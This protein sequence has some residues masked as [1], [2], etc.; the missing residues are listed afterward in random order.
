MHSKSQKSGNSILFLFIFSRYFSVMKLLFINI[1]LVLI[2]TSCNWFK[3]KPLKLTYSAKNPSAYGLADGS[4]NLHIEGGRK[5]YRVEWSN[6]QVTQ[7][8]TDLKA[9]KYLAMV[10]DARNKTVL[11]NIELTCYAL[12]V[13]DLQGNTYKTMTFGNKTWMVEN[14]RTFTKPDGSPVHY[15]YPSNDSSQ[16]QQYGLLYDWETAMNGSSAENTQGICPSGWHIPSD[17]EWTELTRAF[18]RFQA[19]KILMDT[20]E[21]FNAVA[22]GFYSNDYHGFGQ[23]ANFWTSTVCADNAWKRFIHKNQGEV[24]RYHG[25]KSHAYSVRCVKDSTLRKPEV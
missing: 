25:L 7:N 18:P 15:Y 22:A 17:D 3:P 4:I 14:L 1:I 6:N 11:L 2:L 10:T 5:P 19:G 12:P 24:F 8:I 9:G 13:T 23:S 16:T 21:G 20:I